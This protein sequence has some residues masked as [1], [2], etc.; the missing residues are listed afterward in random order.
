M[1]NGRLHR[2]STADG[3]GGTQISENRKAMQAGIFPAWSQEAE[4]DLVA[5]LSRRVYDYVNYALGLSLEEHGQ[6]P[7]MSIQYFGRGYNDTSPDRYT[8]HCDGP[9]D[10]EPF[11]E[12]SRMA[13]M[14]I[15]CD[16]PV[17]GGHTNFQNANVHIKPEVGNGIFFSYFDPVT[18]LTDKA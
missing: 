10:G 2:A 16:I 1:A 11:L 15:Y 5:Q 3:K 13:T 6:E 7:L 8:P 18:N 4:G 17:K 14:V 9:C 12:G